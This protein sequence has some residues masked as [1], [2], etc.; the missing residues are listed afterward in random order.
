MV[1]IAPVV[2]ALEEICLVVVWPD[3]GRVHAVHGQAEVTD[4]SRVSFLHVVVF[5]DPVLQTWRGG[6]WAGQG[7]CQSNDSTNEIKEPEILTWG[8][9]AG[10]RKY[11]MN[12]STNEIKDSVLQT[13]R[14]GEWAGQGKCQM[15][16]STNEIKD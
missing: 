14:G 15:N 1:V 8:K 7:K 3:E 5:K 6:E 11:Q 10:Q 4:W 2:D 13:W 9:E 16:V 12:V